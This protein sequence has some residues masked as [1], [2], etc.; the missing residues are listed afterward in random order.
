MAAANSGPLVLRASDA[1]RENV[2]EALR[3]GAAEGRLSHDTFLHRVSI[4]LRARRV[5]E[6]TDLLGDLPAPPR[7]APVRGREFVLRA[8]G[9]WSAFTT[10][11]QAAWQRPRQARLM[12]PRGDQ[13]VLRIGRSPDC[14]LT[15]PD[16]TVSWLHAELRR[17]GDGWEVGDAGSKNGTRVNGWRVGSGLVVRPGDCVTFGRTAL[18]VVD[19]D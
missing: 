8:V 6:L 4:A 19:R 2:I 13:T 9:W 10:D 16:P 11:L 17:T 5:Q 1:D 12:L 7:Q 18:R 15:L 14:D 3:N